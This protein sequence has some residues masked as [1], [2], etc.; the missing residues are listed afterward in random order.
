MHNDPYEHVASI[1]THTVIIGAP[2]SQKCKL[3]YNNLRDVALWCYMGQPHAS[4]ASYQKLVK[5]L[6]HQL[7]TSR[8]IKMSTTNL[9]NIQQGS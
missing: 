3:L 4:I 8:H 9:F 2:D 7:A 6:M 5:K 1:N